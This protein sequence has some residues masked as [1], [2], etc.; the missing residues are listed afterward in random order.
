MGTVV[1]PKIAHVIDGLGSGG[2]EALLVT[3]LRH[4]RDGP[5]ENIVILVMEENSPAYPTSHFWA[6]EVRALGVE[7]IELRCS[8]TAQ[9]GFAVA[10]LAWLLVRE[11]VS[12]VHTHLLWAGLV[13]RLAASLARVP[14]VSSI[15]I[16][17]YAP[18]VLG[19]YQEPTS[20]K[21]NV[22]RA[23]ETVSLRQAA[24][25]VAVGQTVL[26]SAVERLRV[27][28]ERIR[29]VYN[30]VDFVAQDDAPKAS[31]RELTREPGL[32]ALTSSTLLL[33]V[34]RVTPQKNQV[35]LV[36]AFARL[37][38]ER[39]DVHLVILGALTNAA[40]VELVRST[41]RRLKVSARVH[42]LGARKDVGAWLACSD[43]FVFASHYEGLAVALIEAACAGCCCV[44]SD[45]SQN[46]EIVEDE[47]SA[48]IAD[49]N[50]PALFA[51]ALRR[52]LD[53]QA[54]RNRLG[55]HARESARSRFS[56]QASTTGLQKIYTG[57]LR[58]QR[59]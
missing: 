52:V 30:P 39:A 10:K 36:E 57:V 54:L 12:V 28:R 40:Y 13:G 7:L 1:R 18:E 5:F 44:V 48:L 23:L 3:N 31:R 37:G 47:V 29:V 35:G 59:E 50:D 8:T 34:G 9:C 20:M 21:H 55:Q 33:N 42:L 24:A 16:L 15:H 27:P 19:S 25:I 4:L 2:A 49:Q 14:S 43:I 45:I 41:A 6:S 38:P 17:S 51:T 46:R 11:R 26:E 58:Y 32:G 56:P 53:D 22:M